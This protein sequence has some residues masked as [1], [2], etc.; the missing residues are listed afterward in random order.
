MIDDVI[1][2]LCILDKRN[3]TA[4]DVNKAVISSALDNIEYADLFLLILVLLVFLPENTMQSIK[5]KIKNKHT[6]SAMNIN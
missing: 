2:E 4:K 6:A 1:S 5:K 3:V